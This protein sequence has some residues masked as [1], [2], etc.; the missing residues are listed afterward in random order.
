MIKIIVRRSPYRTTYQI[1]IELNR[2]ASLRHWIESRSYRTI[3]SAHRGVSHII[4]IGMNHFVSSSERIV[5]CHIHNCYRNA[6][7]VHRDSPH[8]HLGAS[9]A[10]DLVSCGHAPVFSER[11]GAISIVTDGMRRPPCDKTALIFAGKSTS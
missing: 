9:A 11:N 1:G 8:T 5:L 3:S 10:N 2:V 4:K 7:R 6:I